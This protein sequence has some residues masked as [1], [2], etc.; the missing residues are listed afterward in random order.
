MVD[1][2]PFNEAAVPVSIALLLATLATSACAQLPPEQPSTELAR[3]IDL[4]G[5]ATCADDNQCRVI[6]IGALPC[7][8][9]ERYV[10]WSV[11][12]TAE[13][14]LRDSA[15]RYAEVRRRHYESIGLS[16]TCVV[17]PEPGARCERSRG[18]APGR[19]VLVPAAPGRPL[20]R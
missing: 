11:S 14:A 7:G 5:P 13:T 19:C 2:R 12:A 4:I 3:I 17:Q 18:D 8:G 9:P 1:P 15:A 6:G 16:S 10:P 20:I